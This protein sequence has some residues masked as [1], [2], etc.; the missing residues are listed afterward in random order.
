MESTAQLLNRIISFALLDPRIDAV[1]MTGSRARVTGVDNY[2][3]LDIEFVGHGVN[4]FTQST[5]WLN[6]FG[7]PLITLQL[8]NEKPNEPDWPTCL[9]IFE[10][11]RKIDFT[12]AEPIR[13]TTM[14]HAGLDA[15]YARGYGVLLDK[16]GVTNGLPEYIPGQHPRISLP[17]A[18]QFNA[19]VTDFWFEA[20]Q[21]AILLTRNERWL[22]WQ[23]DHSM[24]NGLLTLLEWLVTID[25]PNQDCWYQGKSFN[26]WMPKRYL[27][28]MD[29]I[30]NFNNANTAASG[31]IL[32]LDTFAKAS[33]EVANALNYPDYSSVSQKITELA[34][35]I[36]LDNQL[37]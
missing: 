12:F 34:N 13:L 37:I 36:L 21:V 27:A 4:D 33:K 35:D 22:A 24:K 18:E 9:V 14:K 15:I 20:H 28:C 29:K 19:L 5:Q 1:I 32:L 7:N 26:Q 10:Q 23:R 17:S 30:F 6:Q 16:S 25:N 3:D 31:L 11:G 2:S 8:A